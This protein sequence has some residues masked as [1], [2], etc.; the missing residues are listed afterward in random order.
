MIGI[1][2]FGSASSFYF[3]G[4]PFMMSTRQSFNDRH[5]LFHLLSTAS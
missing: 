1:I 2:G 5:I 3:N 4:K